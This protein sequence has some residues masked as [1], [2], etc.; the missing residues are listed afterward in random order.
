MEQFDPDFEIIKMDA[1]VTSYQEDFDS[2]RQ[3]DTH[4]AASALEP[5]HAVG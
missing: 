5:D 1:E 3:P 4:P 2:D